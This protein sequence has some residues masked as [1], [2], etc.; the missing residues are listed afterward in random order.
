[1]FYQNFLS[2]FTWNREQKGGEKP[3]GNVCYRSE[4]ESR[5]LDLE[6][7]RDRRG[8]AVSLVAFLVRVACLLPESVSWVW[9][10]RQSNE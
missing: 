1:M 7:W 9:G 8:S 4:D 10:L 5:T 3:Q 6:E 2:L